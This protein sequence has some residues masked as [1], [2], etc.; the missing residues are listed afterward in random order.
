MIAGGNKVVS[1]CKSQQDGDHA[2]GASNLEDS[3][4]PMCAFMPHIRHERAKWIILRCHAAL[5]GATLK[6]ADQITR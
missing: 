6:L 5:Q 2:P 4:K 1:S 3:C